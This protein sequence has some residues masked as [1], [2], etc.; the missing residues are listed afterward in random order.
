M[1][2]IPVD[3]GGFRLMVSESPEVKTRET[4]DGRTEVVTEY[5]TD[6]QLF[7]VSLFAKERRVDGRKS[8]GEEIKVTLESDPGDDVAEGV[9]VELVEARVSPYSFK[10][11]KGETVSGVAFRAKGLKPRAA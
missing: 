8:K 10:N 3:L 4:V 5:G 1:R 11:D 9:Y 7:T 2:N 6:V